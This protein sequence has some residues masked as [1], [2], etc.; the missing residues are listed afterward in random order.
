MISA[1]LAILKSEAQRN[2]M[3]SVYENNKNLFLSIAYKRLQNE[4]NAEDAVQEAFLRIA[5]KP[6][7]FFSLNDDQKIMYMTAVV[8]NVSIQMFNNRRR[9]QTEELS[10]D[11]AFRNDE[12]LIENS[13]FD[14]LSRDEMLAFIKTLS[15]ARRTVLTLSYVV[16]LSPGE[17]G[18][19]LN[20]PV[21]V[22]YKRLYVARKSVKKFID[23]RSKNNV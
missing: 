23:E 16:G 10:E 5:D 3:S 19:T 22:V 4:E 11:V 20:I 13:F 15:E 8:K 2:E 21:Q 1:A 7:I 12:N 18:T 14:K 17:I 6:E 9:L